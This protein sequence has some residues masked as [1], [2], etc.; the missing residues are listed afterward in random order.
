LEV[1]GSIEDILT[2]YNN[3]KAFIK[4]KIR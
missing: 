4:W 3:I 1:Y 2:S